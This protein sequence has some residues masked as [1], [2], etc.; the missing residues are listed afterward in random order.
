[1]F[2]YLPCATSF[3]RRLISRHRS[4]WHR[5]RVSWTTYYLLDWCVWNVSLDF[6]LN[7][8]FIWDHWRL[9]LLFHNWNN[10]YRS[11]L[12]RLFTWLLLW[13]FLVW[14]DCSTQWPF[15]SGRR[16]NVWMV[17]TWSGTGVTHLQFGLRVKVWPMTLD[18]VDFSDPDWEWKDVVSEL[19][20]FLQSE[21]VEGATSW[22]AKPLWWR[23]S[24]LGQ[25]A[26][27]RLGDWSVWVH[28]SPWRGWR[29]RALLLLLFASDTALNNLILF[30]DCALEPFSCHHQRFGFPLCLGQD[31][32]YRLGW[33][34]RESINN[35]F[36]VVYEAL[37]LSSCGLWEKFLPL[38]RWDAAHK[39]K[40]TDKLSERLKFIYN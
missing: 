10:L 39:V 3:R 4:D 9:F 6:R 5:R 26:T 40:F 1:M 27:W 16:F 13:R 25:T 34:S 28:L 21:L 7:G 31:V 11:L 15:V 32:R 22:I 18:Q 24:G 37:R 23:L 33:W 29:T 20:L 12:V 35:R 36:K 38:F 17:I 30:G 8:Y 2:S 19:R 14:P